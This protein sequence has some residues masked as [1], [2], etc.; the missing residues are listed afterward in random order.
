MADGEWWRVAG[1]WRVVGQG[2]GEER[3]GPAEP[4]EDES[5]YAS[6]GPEEPAGPAAPVPP[7]PARALLVAPAAAG[8]LPTAADFPGW[9]SVS[10]DFSDI[11][12]PPPPVVPEQRAPVALEPEPAPGPAPKPVAA[13]RAPRRGL[14]TGRR[15]SPLLLLSSAVLVG[16]A[17]T[18]MLL[19]MLAGWG[20]AYLS[21]QL[22]DLSRKFAVLGIPLATMTGTTVWFWGR[23]QG[24]WGAAL[25]P[26]QQVGHEAWGAAP[27]VLRLAAV[28]S[29]LF[30]LAVAL[31][32]RV[33]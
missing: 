22:G 23:A 9:D 24:R 32:R 20:L 12:Q 16:G 7:K 5:V 19:V 10:L 2:A 11:E 14:L 26:G 29:A 1:P 27:G 4:G 30:L 25:Q 31:R 18:G 3:E 28:L 15:P 13:V 8:G 6:Q 33:Q 17:V 21:R